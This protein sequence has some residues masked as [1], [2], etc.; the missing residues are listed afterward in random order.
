MEKSQAWKLDFL[1]LTREIYKRDSCGCLLFFSSSFL[2]Q[3]L[4]AAMSL[5]GSCI[6]RFHIPKGFITE[7]QR[8]HEINRQKPQ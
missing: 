7:L 6:P 2:N 8:S 1:Q 5:T 3:D 4:K